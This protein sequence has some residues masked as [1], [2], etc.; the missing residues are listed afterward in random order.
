MKDEELLSLVEG[1]LHE[2]SPEYSIDITFDKGEKGWE[3]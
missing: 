3:E 1:R 2:I